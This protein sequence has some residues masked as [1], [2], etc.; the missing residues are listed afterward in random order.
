MP[1]HVAE[2]EIHRD[3][4]PTLGYSHGEQLVIGGASEIFVACQGN[5]MSGGP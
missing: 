4:G 1:S 3:Q 2:I 5:I